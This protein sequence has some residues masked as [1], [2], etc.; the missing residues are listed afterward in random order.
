MLDDEWWW[1]R[2]PLLQL[3]LPDHTTRHHIINHT[4]LSLSL[5]KKKKKASNATV[6]LFTSSCRVRV[7]GSGLF[8]VIAIRRR[9]C[10]SPP[11]DEY[12][13]ESVYNSSYHGSKLWSYWGFWSLLF[14]LSQIWPVGPYLCSVFTLHHLLSYSVWLCTAERCTFLYW[15]GLRSSRAHRSLWASDGPGIA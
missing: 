3:L 7:V 9:L 12:E 8:P 13:L 2:H 11:M 4:T 14:L 1:R 10:L 5:L 6:S 15:W